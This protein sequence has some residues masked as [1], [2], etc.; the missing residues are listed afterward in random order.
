MMR[1]ESELT[2]ENEGSKLVRT[3][4][5]LKIIEE[6]VHAPAAEVNY[7]TLFRYA[8]TWDLLCLLMGTLCAI[9]GGSALSLMAV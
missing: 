5:E 3:P 9:A 6:Q 4:E 1:S 8:T 2:P 7:W